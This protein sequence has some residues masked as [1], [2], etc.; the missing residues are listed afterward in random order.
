MAGLN[1]GFM[2]SNEM[3]MPI[4]GGHGARFMLLPIQGPWPMFG[5]HWLFII[6]PQCGLFI[7][8][9][10]HCIA[11][12]SEGRRLLTGIPHPGPVFGFMGRWPG[13]Q[14]SR[15]AKSLIF[16]SGFGFIIDGFELQFML[17]G[18]F[19]GP[20]LIGDGPRIAGLHIIEFGG[21]A[22]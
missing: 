5:R 4:P 1:C 17:I 14:L 7:E 21:R 13:P 22:L 8:L 19:M 11:A 9:G 6:G 10:P 15:R 12:K 16:M 20:P 3:F 2:P 18:P